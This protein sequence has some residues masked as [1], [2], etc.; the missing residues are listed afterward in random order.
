MKEFHFSKKYFNKLIYDDIQSN[1]RIVISETPSLDVFEEDYSL[2]IHT[3]HFDEK[4]INRKYAIEHHSKQEKHFY[5]HLQFKFYTEEIGSFWIRLDFENEDEYKK[6]ILGFIFKIKNILQKMEKIKKGICEEI[7]VLDL[8][9]ELFLE[10]EF[11][12]NKISESLN[13]YQIEFQN[14]GSLNEKINNLAE[15]LF[16]IDFLGESNILK[17]IENSKKIIKHFNFILYLYTIIFLL[18]YIW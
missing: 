18:Y 7:L 14:I 13:K 9:D 8:V 3:N 10:G 17:I 4:T 16:L 11:L 6:A 12:T 5:P 1:I 2:R 15:N